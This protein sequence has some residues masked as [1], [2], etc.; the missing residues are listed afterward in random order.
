M[1]ANWLTAWAPKLSAYSLL[2]RLLIEER[3]SG[4]EFE[5]LF[6]QLYQD[7]PTDWPVQVLDVLEG[8]FAD[9]DELF[10][11]HVHPISAQAE[12][13]LRQRVLIADAQLS[14]LTAATA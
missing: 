1:T 11:K 7:D 2:I 4:S 13:D 14:E 5:S 8:I 6:L 10:G 3:I 12:V 9:L